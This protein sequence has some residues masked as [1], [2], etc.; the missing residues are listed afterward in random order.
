MKTRCS[1]KN[2]T[3]FLLSMYKL[4]EKKY[5]FYRHRNFFS[6]VFRLH[7]SKYLRYIIKIYENKWNK[8]KLPISIYVFKIHFLLFFATSFLVLFP[9]ILFKTWT[10]SAHLHHKFIGSLWKKTWK[11]ILNTFQNNFPWLLKERC[12][13]PQWWK[14]HRWKRS[15]K[16]RWKKDGTRVLYSLHYFVQLSVFPGLTAAS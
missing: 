15:T 14:K 3:K 16:K 9:Q 8:N 1:L 5:N 12:K 7:V 10:N 11:I 4:Q 6:Y 2:P 13:T